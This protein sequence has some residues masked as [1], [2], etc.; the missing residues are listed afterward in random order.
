MEVK[1]EGQ[2]WVILSRKRRRGKKVNEGIEMG[3][4]DRHFRELLKGVKSK[5][6]RGT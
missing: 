6:V 2:V 5:V 1:T 3:E 4:W